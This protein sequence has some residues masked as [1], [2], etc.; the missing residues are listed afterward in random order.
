VAYAFSTEQTA[1]VTLTN[2]NR[3]NALARYALDGD[4]LSF[5][6][7]EFVPTQAHSPHWIKVYFAGT[8]ADTRGV[9][10]LPRQG[11]EYGNLVRSNGPKRP[12]SARALKSPPLHGEHASC[13]RIVQSLPCL[14]LAAPVHHRATSC[15]VLRDAIAD[16]VLLCDGEAHC[17]AMQCCTHASSARAAVQPSKRPATVAQGYH[18]IYVSTD[19]D[20]VLEADV[21]W[22][23]VST[24]TWSNSNLEKQALW[25][26]IPARRISLWNM[27]PSYDPTAGGRGASADAGS[28]AE[29]NVLGSYVQCPGAGVRRHRPALILSLTCT[30]RRHSVM[31]AR[32]S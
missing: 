8:L 15:N 3:R 26:A 4:I 31:D 21:T 28:A 32:D 18:E 2:S 14:Q 10:I 11:F 7:T 5:W 1:D 16:G 17:A 29:I 13:A 6:R 20:R 23:L 27:L 9:V 24:G 19:D 22:T 25:D 30:S 12:Q